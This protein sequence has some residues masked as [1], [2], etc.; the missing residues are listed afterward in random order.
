M[1]AASLLAIPR[2]YEHLLPLLS[3]TDETVPVLTSKILT[4]LLM[5]SLASTS[6]KE[7]PEADAKTALPTFLSHLASRSQDPYHVDLAVQS[8]VSLLRSSYARLTFWYTG[9]GLPTLKKILDTSAH[10]TGSPSGVAPGGL[11]QGGVN[12]QLLY[13]VLLVFWELTFEEE[14]AEKIAECALP[15]AVFTYDI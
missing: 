13:H 1:F 5:I 10:G 6:S 11:I 3:H 7:A 2:P 8:Y 12:L 14:I 4:T 15:L 9:E